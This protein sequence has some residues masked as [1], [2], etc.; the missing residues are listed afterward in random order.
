MAF[1]RANLNLSSS[2][3]ADAPKIWTYKSADAIATVNTS[4]YFN[5]ASGELNVGDMM[6]CYDTATPTASLVVVLS[7]ASGVVDVSDGTAVS[8][9]DAD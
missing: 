7:N 5:D 1:A 3:A 9:A 8:V 6:Y 4:G 2:G